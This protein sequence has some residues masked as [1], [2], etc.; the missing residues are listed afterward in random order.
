MSDH[1]I[2]KTQL[3]NDPQKLRPHIVIV[4]SGASVASFPKGDKNGK[5]L[6]TMDNLVEVI[7]LKKNF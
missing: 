2:S 3:I 4:G 1:R 7:G 5:Q 6:P